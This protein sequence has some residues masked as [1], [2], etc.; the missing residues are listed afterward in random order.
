MEKVRKGVES[1]MPCFIYGKGSG[2]STYRVE[3][4]GLV[5]I[6]NVSE[7]ITGGTFLSEKELMKFGY[8]S[9]EKF[10]EKFSA[11]TKKDILKFANVFGLSLNS[12]LSK[13][14]MIYNF[15]DFLIS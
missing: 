1:M 8:L 11:M 9:A 2:W 15:V 12:K 5:L 13:I 6:F 14:D 3:E 7:Q 4:N 10:H